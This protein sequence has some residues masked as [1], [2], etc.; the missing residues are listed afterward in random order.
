MN[1]VVANSDRSGRGTVEP[2]EIT[3]HGHRVS[4][5]AA[6]SGPLLVRFLGRAGLR[7]GPDL[8]EIWRSFVSLSDP[9]I[10][11][12]VERSSV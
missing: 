1:M 11:R 5:R 2:R 4:Y 8:D 9:L 6:R 7:A 12:D 3:L 10:L